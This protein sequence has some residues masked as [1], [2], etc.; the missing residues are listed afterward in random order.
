V[1]VCLIGNEYELSGRRIN[2]RG[3]WL[4]IKGRVKEKW[5]KLNIVDNGE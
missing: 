2:M 4:E 3:K 5:G 1:S